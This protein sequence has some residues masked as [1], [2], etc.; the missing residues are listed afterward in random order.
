MRIPIKRAISVLTLIICAG[1][2]SDNLFAAPAAAA[3]RH[4]VVVVWDGMRPDSVTEEDAPALWKLAKEGVVFRNHHS[5]YPSATNVNG[6]AL[7]T[8][9]YPGRNGI[10]ANHV[11]Q[12]EIDNQKSIDVEN[13]EVV[14]KGDALSGGKYVAFPTI[15]ELVRAAGR[16]TVTATAKTVGLLQDRHFDLNRDKH[17]AVLVS[18]RMQSGEALAALVKL[19]GPFPTAYAQKDIWTTKALTDVFWK[20]RVPVFSLLWLSEPDGTQHE[21][22]PGSPETRAAVKS[23]DDNLASVIVALDR[24]G[25]RATT[26][27]FVVSDHGFSTIERSIDLR[28][29]LSE[30]NFDAATEFSSKPK[31]G[32]IMLSGNAGTVFFYVVQHD[33]AVT[34]RLVEFLQQ[35][36]FAGVILTRDKMPGTFGLEQA[37]IENE[38]APDVA[39]AFRWNDKKNQFGVPGM[40]DADW[41]R[42]AGKGTH[43]TLSRFDMHNTLIA[44]GPSLRRGTTDDYPTG[45]VDLAP[46]ILNILGITPPKKMDGRILG[47]VLA[48]SDLAVPRPEPE[49]LDAKRDFPSGTWR[50]KLKIFRIGSTIYLDEGNGSFT[51]NKRN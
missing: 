29:I 15:A 44:A 28:K 21:T 39:M 2:A 11:Y 17:S 34:R 33:A 41:E 16:P 50:Q 46:T 22:A 42:A 32:Q 24:L 45:N 5:V 10:M 18:G 12:P 1:C 8:G 49:F 30:A 47:E 37:K 25:A 51:L 36:D 9:A 43:A 13:P 20:D 6:T 40:I 7:V 35:S 31:P 3:Q 48:D 26:D 38:H 4:V 19:A 27:I 14:K 23:A